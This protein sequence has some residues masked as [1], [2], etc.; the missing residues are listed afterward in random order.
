[1]GALPKRKVSK[2][3]QGKRRAHLH[4]EAVRLVECSH[5]HEPKVPHTVCPH[6]GYYRGKQILEIKTKKE[7]Q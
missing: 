6:C 7:K 1:M 2:A 3:R 5:C 4:L